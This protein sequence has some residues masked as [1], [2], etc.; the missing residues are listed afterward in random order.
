M[1]LAKAQVLVNGATNLVFFGNN[2]NWQIEKVTFTAT[3]NSTPIVIAGLEPG[4][5]LDAV[6]NNVSD[7]L[8]PSTTADHYF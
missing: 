1:S 8:K 6:T 7:S 3:G 4:M 2:T 5:L